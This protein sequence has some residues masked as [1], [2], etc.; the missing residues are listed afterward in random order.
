MEPT[1]TIMLVPLA[2][3]TLATV[4]VAVPVAVTWK[5][6]AAT[7]YT[8]SLKTIV[9]VTLV[10]VVEPDVLGVSERTVGGV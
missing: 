4:P 2:A 8:G 6:A 3:E 1:V 9:N 10:A 7:W 5:S